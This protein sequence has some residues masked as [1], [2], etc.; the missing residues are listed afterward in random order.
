MRS[1]LSLALAGAVSAAFSTPTSAAVL[2]TTRAGVIV[3]REAC[4]KKELKF[5]FLLEKT[6]KYGSNSGR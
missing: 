5:K 6:S 2:C 1:V 3:V 4:K